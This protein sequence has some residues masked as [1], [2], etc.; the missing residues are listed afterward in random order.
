MKA[1]THRHTSSLHI[2]YFLAGVA[3]NAGWLTVLVLPHCRHLLPPPRQK[4]FDD[5]GLSVSNQ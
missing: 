1:N 4:L 3:V 5:V 2:Q